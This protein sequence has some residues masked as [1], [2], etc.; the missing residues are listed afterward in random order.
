MKYVGYYFILLFIIF[1]I[2]YIINIVIKG[3]MKKLG[4][5]AGFKYI[6][7]QFDLDMNEKRAK[8][9]ARILTLND[10]IIISIPIYIDIFLFNMDSPIKMIA[11][12]F[13]S[14]TL[15]VVFILLSYKTIGKVLKKKGW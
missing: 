14:F 15:F 5:S 3:K 12:F 11:F 10:S 13:L 8:T 2:M 4:D 7:R 6:E 1:L 9:L